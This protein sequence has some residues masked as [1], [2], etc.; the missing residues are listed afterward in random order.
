MNLHRPHWGKAVFWGTVT[1]ARYA[2]MF[3]YSDVIMHMAYVTPDACIIGHGP[4]AVY[5]HK[6][7]AA[8]CAAKGGHMEA[9]NGL[10]VLL[11]VLIAFAVSF[12]HGA[13]TGL[14]WEMMGLKPATQPASH[15]AT[16][17]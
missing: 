3:S 12:V 9:G 4:A 14:F 17:R 1:A 7:E 11:P 16:P 5:L 15:P 13:F 10:R 2:A 6:V 8:A